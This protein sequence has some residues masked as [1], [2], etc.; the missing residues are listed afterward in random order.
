MLYLNRYLKT[1]NVHQTKNTLTKNNFKLKYYVNL[2]YII[3]LEHFK[4]L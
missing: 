3:L 2:L 1:N 4:I